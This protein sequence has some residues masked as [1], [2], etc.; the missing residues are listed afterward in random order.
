[1]NIE[2]LYLDWIEDRGIKSVFVCRKCDP[3]CLQRAE[4]RSLGGQLLL[5]L[6]LASV[7]YF[8]KEL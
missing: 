6:F 7:E 2:H 4:S 1:M 8:F 3:V 5:R